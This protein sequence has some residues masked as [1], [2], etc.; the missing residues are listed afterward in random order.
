LKI[1]KVLEMFKKSVVRSSNKTAQPGEVLC[2]G[3]ATCRDTDALDSLLSRCLPPLLDTPEV[4]EAVAK[5][6]AELAEGG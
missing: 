5:R 1:G 2:M 3:I 6:R 4:I